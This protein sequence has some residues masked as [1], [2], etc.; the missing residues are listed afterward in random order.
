MYMCVKGIDFTIGFWIVPTVWYFMFFI[1]FIPSSR[2]RIK[3]W[4]FKPTFYNFS[5]ILAIGRR[6]Q[7]TQRTQL[8]YRKSLINVIIYNGIYRIYVAT[9]IDCC[10]G[11]IFKQT[12]PAYFGNID[13]CR[14]K[15]SLT[16]DDMVYTGN[17]P[18]CATCKI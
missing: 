6:H 11:M 18:F 4:T 14:S 15:T 2:A 3:L 13:R 7:S 5:Y 16:M 9:G 12:S 1:W 8:I 10:Q 17:P